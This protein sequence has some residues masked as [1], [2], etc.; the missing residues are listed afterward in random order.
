MRAAGEAGDGAAAVEAVRRDKPDVVL[1]DIR[2]PGMDGI[3][4]TRRI[5]SAP[6]TAGTRVLVLTTFD[7]DEYV[8]AALR[9]GASGFL[10]KDTPPGDLLAAI[11]VVA[12]GD[13]LL[14][15]GLTRKLIAEFARQ[16]ALSSA[17]DL[18]EITEREREVLT[19][20]GLGLSNDEIA[21]KLYVS[22][23][24]A[25]T[26]IG[27]LLL[28]LGAR[29]RAQL[30]IAAYEAGLVGPGARQLLR[31]R[32]LLPPGGDLAVLHPAGQADVQHLRCGVAGILGDGQLAV[33]HPQIV[34]IHHHPGGEDQLHV[35]AP[36]PQFDNQLGSGA[37]G[38]G[39]VQHH[40][41][42]GGAQRQPVRQDPAAVAAH[43]A[44]LLADGE[45]FDCRLGRRR[46]QRE[47]KRA[48]GRD[49]V[50]G[51]RGQRSDGAGGQRRF[52]SLVELGLIEPSVGD[53]DAQQ[54]DD[55]VAVR[56]GRAQRGGTGRIGRIGRHQVSSRPRLCIEHRPYS[57]QPSPRWARCWR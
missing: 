8:F 39:Q 6:E 19:L 35:A 25:K 18:T 29:D 23:S 3:E 38:A 32:R 17:A 43:D 49:Q 36:H 44:V 33:P 52:D 5:T 54:F 7:L 34:G 31:F 16:P 42:P 4:A 26:H 22:M 57:L 30:V 13:A 2:M 55:P 11:R 56:I 12:S 1:M 28:K 41:G 53:G 9:A 14:A 47:H 51:K 50:G 45:Q 15:P 37:H 10:L 24:T 46:R 40:V 21:G 20:I 27:R 48:W